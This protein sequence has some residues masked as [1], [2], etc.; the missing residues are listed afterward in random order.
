MQTIRWGL[1]QG[2][3]KALIGRSVRVPLTGVDQ[4]RA[5]VAV[6]APVLHIAD[7]T[8]CSGC[9]GDDKTCGGVEK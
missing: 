8:G 3:V 4:D 2:S 7:C 6:D 9:I 1:Q 5:T